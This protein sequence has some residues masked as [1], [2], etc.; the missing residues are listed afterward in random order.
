MELTITRVVDDE[1]R[2][3]LQVVGAIDVQ[4]RDELIT[5]GQSQVASPSEDALVLDLSGV[6]FMDSTGIGALVELAREAADAHRDFIISRPSKRVIRVLELTG[7]L[8]E[9]A[10]EFEVAPP[11]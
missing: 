2:P 4:S 5:A 9:W 11:A 7:L 8:Q 6:T 10:V 1:G 3:A